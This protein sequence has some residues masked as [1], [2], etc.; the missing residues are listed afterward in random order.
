MSKPT[1]PTGQEPACQVTQ[2]T[3]TIRRRPGKTSSRPPCRHVLVRG[4]VTT[5]F[6]GPV[7]SALFGVKLDIGQALVKLLLQFGPEDQ[8]IVLIPGH[9]PDAGGHA[10]REFNVVAD[11]GKMK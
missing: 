4:A 8:S 7:R 5:G 9:Y 2:S 3:T 6:S 10:P 1:S 11:M